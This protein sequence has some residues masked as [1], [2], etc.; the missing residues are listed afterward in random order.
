[1]CVFSREKSCIDTVL[2]Y[3]VQYTA[4]VADDRTLVDHCL[5]PSDVSNMCL[6]FYSISL[7]SFLAV[8]LMSP[9]RLEYSALLFFVGLSG[10]FLYTGGVGF[11]YYALGDIL[12]LILFGPVA[13]TF[14]YMLQTGTFAIKSIMFAAPLAFATEAIL[15]CNNT[16]DIDSD[17]KSGVRTVAIVLGKQL[18]YV[19]FCFLLFTP[20]LMLT[21]PA[22]K[23]SLLIFLPLLTITHAFEIEKEFRHQKFEK[24]PK[25][26]AHLM[27]SFGSVYIISI[28]LSYW[29]HF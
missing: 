25:K 22:C 11:K 15:H 3:R 28:L 14:S 13:V 10:S 1:M 4:K 5:K 23:I 16:R 26:T 20:Y 8:S 7:F 27:F 18:S 29:V 12:I 19:F 17:Q 6:F 21:Y 9:L 24:L 2:V